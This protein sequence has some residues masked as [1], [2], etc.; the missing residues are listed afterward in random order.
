MSLMSQND[1]TEKPAHCLRG[2]NIGSQD[3]SSLTLHLLHL[4]F[5]L[6]CTERENIDISVTSLG[7]VSETPFD[8]RDLKIK[9]NRAV[10]CVS[11]KNKNGTMLTW[12]LQCMFELPDGLENKR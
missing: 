10:M 11:P 2:D 12:E 5:S 1:C 7:Q 3:M 8:T 4:G 6:L 9:V